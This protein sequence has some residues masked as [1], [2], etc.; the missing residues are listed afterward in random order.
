MY[1]LYH[2]KV[3]DMLKKSD[4]VFNVLNSM[5]VR[6]DAA[7]HANETDFKQHGEKSTAISNKPAT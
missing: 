1:C 3:L 5:F 6:K 2:S 7:S 4:Y